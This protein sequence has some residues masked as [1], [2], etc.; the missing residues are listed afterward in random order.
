MNNCNHGIMR[1]DAKTLMRI[2]DECPYCKIDEL[3]ATL[4]SAYWRY[5]FAGQA[6]SGLLNNGNID[7]GC[8]EIAEDSVKYSDALLDEL[9]KTDRIS[10][11]K[12]I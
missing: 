10:E 11:N 6:M 7:L 9:E 5:H 1:I 3:E 8:E 12:K 2:N 4:D